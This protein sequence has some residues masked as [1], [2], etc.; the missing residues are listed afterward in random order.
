MAKGRSNDSPHVVEEVEVHVVRPLR[1]SGLRPGQPEESVHYKSDEL[2]SARHFVVRDDAHE[3]I[4]VGSMHSEN[5]VAGHPPHRTPGLRVRGM[6]VEPEWRGKGIG[7]A[8]L[9][10]M[11]EI[12]KADGVAE[13]WA[14]ARVDALGIYARAGFK[15]L[16]SEFEIPGIGKHVVIARAV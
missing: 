12:A 7:S 10:Q 5:R 3:V 11:V 8:I 1:H 4:G 13:V 6:A 9:T 16:S 2:D 14:N 15:E